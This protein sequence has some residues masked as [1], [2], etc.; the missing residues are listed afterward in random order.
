MTDTQ[1]E[2]TDFL[3]IIYIGA[4][5]SWAREPT[6]FAAIEQAKKQCESDWGSIYRFSDEPAHFHVYDAT[7]VDGWRADCHGVRSH[8]GDLLRHLFTATA[9]LKNRKR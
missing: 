6:S 1:T 5:S 4:G 2:P 8:S 9:K 7:G 3:A